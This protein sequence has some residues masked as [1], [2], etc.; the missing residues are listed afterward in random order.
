[1]RNRGLVLR[2]FFSLALLFS[3]SVYAGFDPDLDSLQDFT[4]S[5]DFDLSG[6]VAGGS[7]GVTGS[8]SYAVYAPGEY[9]GSG[10]VDSS[11]YVYAYQIF[12]D[13]GNVPVGYLSIGLEPDTFVD[14][15]FSADSFSE[16]GLDIP[17][18]LS[19]Q[20]A[21]EVVFLFHLDS[22]D[23]GEHSSLLLFTSLHAPIEGYATVSLGVLGGE[24]VALPTP[25]PE[26]TTLL[27][28]A[29]GLMRLQLAN[30]RR[31]FAA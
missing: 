23:S 26:P 15:A 20:M 18:A 30:R 11:H 16:S 3:C 6:V 1:M 2:I 25:N 14:N 29:G 22:I 10:E 31:R 4:G 17:A 27:L 19:A 5:S 13:T 8:V 21:Q 7:Y 12:N 9:S 28:F 24:A